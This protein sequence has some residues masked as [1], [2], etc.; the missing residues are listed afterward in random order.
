MGKSSG[1]SEPSSAATQDE[2]LKLD[3]SVFDS[4]DDALAQ[5]DPADRY[6]NVAKLMMPLGESGMPSTYASMFCLSTI[7]RSEGLH[8]AIAREINQRNPYAVFPLL[9][10]FVEAVVLVIYVN[11]RPD[12]V[13]VLSARPRELPKDG[14]KRKSIQALISYA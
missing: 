14:P 10:A 4:L 7:T 5:I 3:L 1:T 6:L 12:Y 13:K 9:R 8:S 2:P 11:D